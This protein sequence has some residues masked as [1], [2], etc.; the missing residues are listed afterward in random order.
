[1]KK[2]TTK[3]LMSI[4]AVAFAFVALGTSTYAWFSMNTTVQATGMQITAKSDSTFL[5]I[6]SGDKDTLAEVQ[7]EK[8]I[9][10]TI[11]V[12]TDEAKVYPSAHNEITSATAAGTA[13]NWYY[14]T[15][16]A[17]NASASSSA[18]VALTDANFSKYV[19]KRT[20]YITLAPGSN[21][22]T[23]LVVSATFASNSTATGENSNLFTPV[24]AVVACGNN[25]V[26]LDKATTSSNTA[27]AATVTDAALVTV[28][29]YLY[30]NG[31]DASVFTENIANLDGATVNFSFSVT[32][33][34]QGA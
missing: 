15:A 16:D 18:A 30:Y 20:V 11:A 17:P 25:V 33:A 1:M 14:Q 9:L 7:A 6:N 31:A 8:A 27:L 3:L 12:G 24:K 2:L 13:A 34:G 28:D 4:I 32:T 21:D 10:T 22:A 5:L 26:E 19:I 23:N 29:I